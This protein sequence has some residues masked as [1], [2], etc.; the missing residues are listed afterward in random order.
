MAHG[1]DTLSDLPA[2]ERQQNSLAERRGPKL[3]QSSRPKTRAELT[4]ERK[5]VKNRCCLSP[6]RRGG[7]CRT[8]CG[9]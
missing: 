9:Q 5:V 8:C 6:V 4:S 3:E 7:T 1:V 2:H